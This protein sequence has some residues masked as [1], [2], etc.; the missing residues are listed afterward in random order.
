MPLKIT[1]RRGSESSPF[2][3]QL[4]RLC[5]MPTGG[6]LVLSSGY[7]WEPESGYRVLNDELLD[8]IIAGIKKH[9]VVTIAGKLQ[10]SGKSDWPQ[11]YRNFVQTLRTAGIAVEPYVAP[12]RNWHA[13]VAIRLD[14]AGSPVAAIVG[15][16][17]LTGPAYAENRYT[18][19]YECDVTIWVPKAELDQYFR[20]QSDPDPYEQLSC[21][22]DPEIRQ[23]NEEE[24]LRELL[25]DMQHDRNEFIILDEYNE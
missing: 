25:A 3:R 2:R 13:K 22:L 18:W 11:Y 15:S 1:L 23:P 12:K 24:R 10:K 19:N 14:R 6:D 4:L 20:F 21:I 9:K 17:N 8:S 5:Q 7:I 16:S